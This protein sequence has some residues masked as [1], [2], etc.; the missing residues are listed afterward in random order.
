MWAE[1]TTWPLS[2]SQ[3]FHIH[4][5]Y[6]LYMPILISDAITEP[7]TSPKKRPTCKRNSV[8]YFSSFA[9]VF[10]SVQTSATPWC[11]TLRLQIKPGT[12]PTLTPGP[13][14]FS[15]RLMSELRKAASFFLGIRT[16]SRSWQM[17]TCMSPSM[18]DFFISFLTIW[19]LA[20]CCCR[21]A[22]QLLIVCMCVELI[23]SKQPAVWLWMV[24]TTICGYSWISVF[25]CVEVKLEQCL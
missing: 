16:D 8:F 14:L 4:C 21:H 23:Q 9:V 17:K 11:Y 19:T 7:S 6:F 1:H 5:S 2:T 18:C 24:I 12:K 13:G 20:V 10:M 3:C 15:V 22:L 25:M